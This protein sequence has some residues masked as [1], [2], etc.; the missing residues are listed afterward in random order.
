MDYPSARRFRRRGVATGWVAAVVLL[1]AAL[2]LAPAL[3][4]R[5]TADQPA[6]ETASPIPPDQRQGDWLVRHFAAEPRTLNPVT[7]KDAYASRIQ[8]YLF[9]TLI[10]IDPDTLEYYG[11]MAE[12]WTIS[13]DKLSIT[14]TLRDGMTWSDGV[15]VTADDVVFSYEVVKDPTVDAARIASYFKDVDRVEALDRRRVR[16]TFKKPY[17]KSLEV[18]GAGYLT[19]IPRHVYAYG[20]GKPYADG[21]AFSDIRKHLVGCGPYVFESWKSGQEVVIRRN[22]RYY[23]KPATFD[24]IVFRIVPD[25]TVALQM[26]KAQELDFMGLSSDQY[27]RVAR[28]RKFNLNYRRMLYD[29]PTGY[30][31]IAWNNRSRFFSDRRV[32]VAMTHLV[33]RRRINKRLFNSL[34]R[35]T[36]GPFWPG[37]EGE[38][39]VPLQFD[40][41]IKPYPF[42]SAKAVV[43]LAEA[44]WR[45]TDGD[46]LL[47]KD[48]EPFAFSLLLP[49]ASEVGLDIASVVKEEMAKVGI[50]MDIQQLEWTVFVTRL[51]DRRYHAISLSWTGSLEGDPY[52]IWHSSSIE[53][54]GSNHVSFDNRESDALIEA[55]RVEFDRDKR[56]ELY[57]KFHRLLHDEQPYTFLFSSRSRAAVHKRFRDVKVHVL[58]LET[59]EWWTPPGARLY[60]ED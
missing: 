60:G 43:L 51:D 22:D 41:S 52:Q 49:S 33:P 6:G 25:D 27:I 13:K 36:T 58:G 21:K 1:T 20:E 10:D 9:D 5:A 53:N 38:T 35:V 50:R 45:D 31:Y 30:S 18:S 37:P 46:G 16:F 14:Y 48:G 55:A 3:C 47:D 7:S 44:G 4:R 54:K 12:S 23:G 40:R 11:K 28:D 57:H 19:Y 15:P 29:A 56:N 8:S 24:R 34:L 26:L 17:F 32:R 39:K 42:D 2:G 59:K